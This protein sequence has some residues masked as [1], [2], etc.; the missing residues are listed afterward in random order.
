M[1]AGLR[2][3]LA[4]GLAAIAISPAAACVAPLSH[5]R[6]IRLETPDAAANVRSG[7]FLDVAVAG[8]PQHRVQVDTGSV[9][10]AIAAAAIP[11]GATRIGSG[12]IHYSSSGKT[13][14]GEVYRAS[15]AFV[16]VPG[17]R[18]VAI[19]I[20]GV[21][22]ITC[23]RTH[24]QECVVAPD[25]ATRVGMLGVG[26]GRHGS[27][28]DLADVVHAGESSINPFL[29]LE[30]M[31]S[32]DLRRT[33]TIFPDHIVLGLAGVHAAGRWQVFGLTHDADGDWNPLAG[34]FRAEPY[35]VRCTAGSVLVDTGVGTTIFSVPDHASGAVAAGTPLSIRIDGPPE[36][37]FPFTSSGSDCSSLA[38]SCARWSHRTR[39]PIAVNTSRRLIQAADYRFDDVCG[40]AAFR[41]TPDRPSP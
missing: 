31:V 21:E 26:F 28:A 27:G 15:I 7:W 9:G 30:A 4:V 18:T 6:E 3:W 2:A 8:G 37:S 40:Q 10:L 38:L 12:S 1:I 14:H 23:D 34:C 16:A 22:R 41:Q 32:G 25:E 19:P 20:L 29:Q 39:Y 11:A 35:H 5:G 17:L 13:L 24:H 36:L 33:Y